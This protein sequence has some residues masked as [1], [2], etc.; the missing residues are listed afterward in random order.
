MASCNESGI[1]PGT[2]FAGTLP[3]NGLTPSVPEIG[4]PGELAPGVVSVCASVVAAAQNK[5]PAS[6]KARMGL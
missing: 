5:I 3:A 2:G 4:W 6:K 1:T